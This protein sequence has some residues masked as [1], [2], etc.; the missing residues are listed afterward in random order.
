MHRLN[1]LFPFLALTLLL[2]S[3]QPATPPPPLTVS[4]DE[5]FVLAPGQSAILADAGLT[6]TFIAV[7]NDARCPSEIECAVS[8]PVTLT[9]SAQK[10]P[11]EA[12]EFIL[13]TFTSNN[14]M[15]PTMEFEGIQDRVMFEGHQI[16]ITSVL[17]YPAKS[18]SEI[19]ASEYRVSFLISLE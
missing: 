9:V 3:C 19:K 14:G 2:A 6:L 15:A 4:V 17:P 10:G 1:L 12:V 7:S 11:G 16:K 13:Q 5:E 18:M 8:G